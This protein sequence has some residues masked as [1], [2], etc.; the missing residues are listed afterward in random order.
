MT[1]NMASRVFDTVSH[2]LPGLIFEARLLPYQNPFLG[3]APS[4]ANKYY[5]SMEI[6]NIDKYSSLSWK[7]NNYGCKKI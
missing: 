7:G 6:T 2:F 5:T 4:F 3:N 1:K